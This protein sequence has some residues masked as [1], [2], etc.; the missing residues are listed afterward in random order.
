MV[1]FFLNET[2]LIRLKLS[3]EKTNIEK[4]KVTT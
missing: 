3:E 1:V 2:Q 4:E